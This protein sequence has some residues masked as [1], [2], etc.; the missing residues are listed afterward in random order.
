MTAGIGVRLWSFDLE[1]YFR[2]TGKQ[3]ADW[4]KSGYILPDGFG[5]DKRVQFG[6]REAPVLTSRQSNFLHPSVGY[7]ARAV[8]CTPS[9]GSISA[10][11]GI[12][13]GHSPRSSFLGSFAFYVI[14]HTDTHTFQGA[15][16]SWAK[17]KSY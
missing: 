1:A 11:R 10:L 13:R 15:A 12:S 6:Q 4:W 7:A 3:R 16:G 5:F 14:Y 17:R 9:I 2:K 8:A